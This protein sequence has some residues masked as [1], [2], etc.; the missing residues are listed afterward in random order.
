MKFKVGDKVIITG[1]KDKGK[2]G[3]ILR[4]LPEV[5]RVVVED[6]NLYTRHVKPMAGR[7]GEKLRVPRSLHT[8]SV[9][10]INDKGKADR[11]G[12]SVAKDGS[13]TRIFKKTGALVPEP[14]IEKEAK[15]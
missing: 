7:A 13:K 8:A 11:I 4:V 15:K 6:A 3:K 9:A 14:K 10:I 5:E 12:F 2:Q 1:G